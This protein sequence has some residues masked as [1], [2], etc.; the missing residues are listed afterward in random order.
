MLSIMNNCGLPVCL[1]GIYHPLAL[2]KEM[3]DHERRREEMKKMWFQENMERCE[4]M[5]R[6]HDRE[7]LG[8]GADTDEDDAE[9]GTVIIHDFSCISLACTA[10]AA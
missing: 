8:D 6:A 4:E 1:S 9:D 10:K 5:S 7:A 2:S 3:A